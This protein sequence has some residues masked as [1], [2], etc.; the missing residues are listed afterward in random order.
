MLIQ[1]WNYYG[2]RDRANNWF[3]HTLKIEVNL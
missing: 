3:L 2:V 1:K